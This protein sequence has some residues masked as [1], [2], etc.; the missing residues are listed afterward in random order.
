MKRN[1]KA[2]A[3]MIDVRDH[4]EFA[5]FHIAEAVN[6]SLT[7][8][9]TKAFLKNK[10]ITLVSNGK[11]EQELY[12]A[13]ADLK[14][15]GFTKTRVLRGGMAAWLA[16]QQPVLGKIPI[17]FG[18]VWLTPQEL[19]QE[20]SFGANVL[21]ATPDA[22]KFKNLLPAVVSIRNDQPG[23]I[24]ESINRQKKFPE[25]SVILL[26]SERFDRAKVGQIIET[27]SPVPVLV[28]SEPAAAYEQFIATQKAV[29]AARQ[30]GPKRPPDCTSG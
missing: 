27:L 24:K 16:K 2:D 5:D 14:A 6:F 3:L 12:S 19:F 20:Q 1:A 8:L 7:E 18:L 9:K 11:G 29:W 10:A 26:V 13:C 25:A 23:T 4:S 30:N 15:A 21:L 22:R 28:Y 17:R